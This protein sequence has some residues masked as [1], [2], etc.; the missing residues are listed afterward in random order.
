MHAARYEETCKRNALILSKKS[1]PVPERAASAIIKRR[2]PTC[3]AEQMKVRT[4]VPKA[5]S[6][7]CGSPREASRCLSVSDM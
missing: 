7:S 1:L 6:A 3:S 4:L 2:T 5:R